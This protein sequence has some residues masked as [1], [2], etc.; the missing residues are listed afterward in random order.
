MRTLRTAT[1][2]PGARLALVTVAVALF[3]LLSMH[4]WGS[5]ATHMME[6]MPHAAH[7]SMADNDPAVMPASDSPTSRHQTRAPDRGDGAGM[8]GLCLAILTGLLLGIAAL[9][10]RRGCRIPRGLLPTWPHPVFVGRD[11]DPPDLLQFC[12][13]RC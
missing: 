8:V 4:G 10:G 1:P 13:I 6:A 3:G 7:A 11:R 5:H 12:V 2:A 9:M